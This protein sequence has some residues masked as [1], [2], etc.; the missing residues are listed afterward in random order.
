MANERDYPIDEFPDQLRQ[1]ILEV[2][3]VTQVPLAMVG[4]EFIA[5]MSIAAQGVYDIR[6]PTGKIRPPT[7]NGVTFADSG[8]RK[9]SAAEMVNEPIKLFDDMRD[10]KYQTALK[11]YLG[12]K[13][14]WKAT[15]KALARKLTKLVQAGDNADEVQIQIEQHHAQT[16]LPPKQV[17]ILHQNTTVRA[18]L[19]T[20]EG[21]AISVAFHSAEGGAITEGGVLDAAV[22][23][24]QAWDGSA[25]LEMKRSHGVSIVARDPRITVAFAIPPAQFFDMGKKKIDMLRASGYFA[26]TLFCYP[27]S[28]Q[29][30]RYVKE[31]NTDFRYLRAFHQIIEK[32]LHKYGEQIDS[33]RVHRD[34]LEFSAEAFLTWA[35]LVNH[36]EDYI[37]PGA[38]FSEMKDVASKAVEMMCRVAALLHIFSGQTGKIAQSTLESAANIVDWY[39]EEFR[40]IFTPG[41]LIPV[42]QQY[43]N[44]LYDF[45][46]R[47][48]AEEGITQYEKNYFNS[49]APLPIR[50]AAKIKAALGILEQCGAVYSW[51]DRKT[52][53]VS[54]NLAHFG[55]VSTFRM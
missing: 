47:K 1:A 9:S 50:K 24:N 22:F 8:E 13:A 37:K 2:S 52:S 20:M 36:A 34:C 19:E 42:E 5:A 43:A 18:L 6:M 10:E 21:T 23:L 28:T 32:C 41:L 33:G 16:P 38:V 17:R 26:R 3:E 31:V 15:E 12:K 44:L 4:S 49:Y 35:R 29:G 7:V 14:V 27:R 39:M 53:M 30:T 54:L 40:R 51:V 46:A 25:Q 45:L 48:L 55:L 11:Q